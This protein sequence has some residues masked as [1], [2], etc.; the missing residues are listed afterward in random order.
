MEAKHMVRDG[1]NAV[2]TCSDWPNLR[3]KDSLDPSPS[4]VFCLVCRT[5]SFGILQTTLEEL[6]ALCFSPARSR[7]SWVFTFN[8]SIRG[9][10]SFDLSLLV[11]VEF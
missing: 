8:S 10:M 6:F 5:P 4:T 11:A 1:T 7:T 2:V 3:G 9:H